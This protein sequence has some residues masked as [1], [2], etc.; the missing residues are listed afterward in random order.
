MDGDSGVNVK[1]QAK[2]TTIDS[3]F[4]IT[5]RNMLVKAIECGGDP[6]HMVEAYIIRNTRLDSNLYKGTYEETAKKL[7][8]ISKSTVQRAM[9]KMQEDDLM[10]MYSRGTWMINPLLI[11][12]GTSEKYMALWRIYCD[13]PQ[14]N[15]KD[16]D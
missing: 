15:K 3:N 9:I 10:R 2:K 8:G 7:N 4:E 13:L 5:H 14:R 11:R 12:R 1:V 6:F 16:S